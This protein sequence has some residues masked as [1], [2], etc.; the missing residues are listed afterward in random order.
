MARGVSQ[1]FLD[2]SLPSV[3]R[4]GRLLARPQQLP[5]VVSLRPASK[6]SRLRLRLECSPARN[7]ARTALGLAEGCRQA[8]LQPALPLQS[9]LGNLPGPPGPKPSDPHGTSS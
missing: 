3:E 2:P 1:N 5:H 6:T 8:L 9:F 7:E 4:F